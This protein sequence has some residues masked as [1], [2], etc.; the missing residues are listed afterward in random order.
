MAGFIAIWYQ[1]LVQRFAEAGGRPALQLRLAVF[2][3]E[4]MRDTAVSLEITNIMRNDA[5][6]RDKIEKAFPEAQIEAQLAGYT[7]M[8]PE[9]GDT[10]RRRLVVSML[11]ALLRG[12]AIEAS[13]SG[14]PID[15]HFNLF[16]EMFL[17]YF[18][19]RP[20][21]QTAR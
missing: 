3:D 12:L 6:L 11:V 10:R 15:E 5:I 20:G 7:E 18:E 9:A 4:F 21:A 16:S 8:F 14:K 13:V 2:R 17:T 1:R 19:S